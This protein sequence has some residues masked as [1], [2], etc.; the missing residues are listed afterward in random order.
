[1]LYN[2]QHGSVGICTEVSVYLTAKEMKYATH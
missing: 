2:I 1:M